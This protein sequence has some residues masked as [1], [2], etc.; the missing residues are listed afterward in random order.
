MTGIDPTTPQ[1]KALKVYTDAIAARD[2]SSVEPHFS[3]DCK[4]MT[5]PTMEEHP[6]MTK[7]QYLKKFG[8]L[9]RLFE[10]IE[11]SIQRPGL[12]FEFLMLT[13]LTAR[14]TSTK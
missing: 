14:S 3:K 7:E 10:K 8:G 12:S 1:L 11:V 2:L 4:F 13:S 9:F 6:D 5:F